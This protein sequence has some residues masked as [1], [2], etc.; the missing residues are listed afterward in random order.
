MRPSEVPTY[1]SGFLFP[2]RLCDSSA[3]VIQETIPHKLEFGKKL[4][5]PT[6]SKQRYLRVDK[7]LLYLLWICITE[8]D[9]RPQKGKHVATQT[10]A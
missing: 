4:C 7:G 9:I 3:A 10:E 1:Q 5:I 2:L 8:A 6:Q